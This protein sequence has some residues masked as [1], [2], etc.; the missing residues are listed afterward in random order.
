MARITGKNG[1]LYAAITSSGTAE[2]IAF[3]NQFSLDFKTDK[4]DVTCFNDT[5]KVYVSGY[6]DASGSYSGF[7]DTATAQLYTASVDGVARK[8]Y[9]YPDRTA[10]SQYWFGTGLFDFSVAE[11]IG[12]GVAISGSWAAASAVSKVG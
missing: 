10:T 5:N 7:Y 2:P 12:G 11:G 8:F 9:F 6:A 3:I 1:L 4:Q